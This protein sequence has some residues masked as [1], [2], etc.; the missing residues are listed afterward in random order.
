MEKIRLE[1]QEKK[2]KNGEKNISEKCQKMKEAKFQKM[3]KRNIAEK[4]KK[5]F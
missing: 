4:G 3:K 5:I 1:N 2:A